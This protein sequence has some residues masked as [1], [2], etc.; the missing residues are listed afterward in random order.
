MAADFLYQKEKT[1]I[2]QQSFSGKVF[3]VEDKVRFFLL[4]DS[5]LLSHSPCV[6]QNHIQEI[7]YP[8]TAQTWF[9][10]PKNVAQAPQNEDPAPLDGFAPAY[11]GDGRTTTASHDAHGKVLLMQGGVSRVS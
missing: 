9:P 8:N 5:E 3:Y 4:L 2:F 10:P 7:S 1:H 11:A 6:L